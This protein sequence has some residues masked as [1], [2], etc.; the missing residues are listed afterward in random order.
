MNLFG[1][2]LYGD[3]LVCSLILIFSVKFYFSRRILILID[4]LKKVEINKL[5]RSNINYKIIL[6]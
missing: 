6:F 5:K 1:E 2:L 3:K 4:M